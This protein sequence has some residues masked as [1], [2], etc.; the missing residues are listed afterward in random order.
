[1]VWKT[2]KDFSLYEVSNTGLVRRKGASVLA[3]HFTN[4]YPRVS[5]Y[6]NKKRKGVLIH[7]LVAESFL[8]KK[9]SP[10]YE[11]DHID[12]DRTNCRVDNL[13]WVT[14]KQNL[15]KRRSPRSIKEVVDSALDLY[16][17]GTSRKEIIETLF[18]SLRKHY[19]K[20]P[21]VVKK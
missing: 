18:P 3:P 20:Q 11:C 7:R 12:K 19:L 6:R 17:S 16:E 14:R 13:Q 9:P 8:E 5:L 10:E 2:I 1:M 15:E 4:G 21:S